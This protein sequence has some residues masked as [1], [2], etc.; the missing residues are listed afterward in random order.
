MVNHIFA[1]CDLNDDQRISKQ[2]WVAQC[3]KD[4][5]LCPTSFS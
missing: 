4:E 5:G 3:A 2:E 1:V